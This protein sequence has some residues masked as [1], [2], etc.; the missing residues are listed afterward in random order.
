VHC[1]SVQFQL[2]RNTA[3]K[4]VRTVA[5]ESKMR[6]QGEVSQ[7]RSFVI[8]TADEFTYKDPVDGSVAEHQGVRFLGR[9]GSRIVFRLSGQLFVAITSQSAF[10]FD[11]SPV[12]L[13]LALLLSNCSSSWHVHLTSTH[14]E[15]KKLSR[16][17]AWLH[18]YWL[19]RGNYS[20]VH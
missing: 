17:D 9:D 2:R 5:S 4:S 11:S 18:R 1:L 10:S 6:L 15:S 16:C 3:D 20:H 7:V 12:F 14:N 13:T 19:I 8:D